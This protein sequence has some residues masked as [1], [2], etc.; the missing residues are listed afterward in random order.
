MPLET[1]G[2][3]AKGEIRST[4]AGHGGYPFFLFF[5]G[6]TCRMPLFLQCC[7]KTGS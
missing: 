1:G 3:E 2:G 5:W 6:G 7:S 4:S